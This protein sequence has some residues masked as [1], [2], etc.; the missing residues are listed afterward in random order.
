MSRFIYN[1]EKDIYLERV[2]FNVNR[3]AWKIVDFDYPAQISTMISDEEKQ[4]LYWLTSSVWRGSGQVVEIGPWL[5]GSTYCL[6]A[7]MQSSGHETKKRLVVYDNFVWREFMSERDTAVLKPGDC[8][9]SEFRKNISTYKSIVDS[10]KQALPDE[11]IQSDQDAIS[12]RYV[13]EENVAIFQGLPNSQPVEILFVDGAKSWLGLKHLLFHVTERLIPAESI[14]V[15]QDFKYWGNYWVPLMLTFLSEYL[16]PIHNVL[17]ATTIT[18]RLVKPIPRN[19][20]EALANH[21]AEVPT[22]DSL[23][24]LDRAAEMLRKNEDALGSAHVRLGKV[25][26]LSHQNMLDQAAAAFRE[27][28]SNWPVGMST[29]QLERA[30][31]YLSESRS[32]YIAPSFLI[33]TIQLKL[34]A[35]RIAGGVRKKILRSVKRGR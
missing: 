20:L 26:F 2:L 10:Y 25:M 9:H 23:A 21:I 15:C 3:S 22:N 19:V 33:R 1:L 35:K 16:Q 18:F 34:R 14:L 6:A 27:C 4:Y 32:L 29:L 7:G 17:S 5:G 31:D 30:R 11:F 12:K 8:F 24:A 13:K 28:Q